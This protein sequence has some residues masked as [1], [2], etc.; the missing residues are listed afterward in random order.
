MLPNPHNEP[1]E[2]DFGTQTRRLLSGV[3]FGQF[4]PLQNRM[5][6]TAI[7]LNGETLPICLYVYMPICASVRP[8]VSPT[9]GQ[10][11]RLW[12]FL[13]LFFLVA[14]P[15]FSRHCI[16]G[17]SFRDLLISHVLDGNP[18]HSHRSRNEL[19]ASQPPWPRT[20]PAVSSSG[21]R[22]Y[23]YTDADRQ[24]ASDPHMPWLAA[25]ER[26]KKNRNH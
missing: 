6:A 23:R 4:E 20:V 13:F 5:F 18:E 21:R 24:P 22:R 16:Y 7:E 15:C 3:A 17:Y 11:E 26:K 12:C 14:A 2:D 8:F 9:L 1:Q 25:G 10:S 19:V